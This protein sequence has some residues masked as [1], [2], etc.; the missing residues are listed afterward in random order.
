MKFQSCAVIFFISFVIG[1]LKAQ[2][3]MSSTDWEF[4]QIEKSMREKE[5]RV[6]ASVEENLA[7]VNTLIAELKPIATLSYTVQVLE[8][9]RDLLIK[10]STIT[11]FGNET[12]VLACENIPLRISQIRF[13]IDKCIRIKI[14]VDTNAVLIYV[15]AAKVN[16]AYAYNYFALTD[17]QRRSLMSI[18]TSLIVLFDEHNSYSV[19]QALAIYKYTRL[20]I[21]LLFCKKTFCNCPTQL[22]AASSSK[23][24]TVDAN[25]IEIQTSVD[26]REANIRKQSTVVLSK[27]DAVNPGLKK[28]ALYIFVTQTLDSIATLVK[29]YLILTTTDMINATT[30]CDEA[31]MKYAFIEYKLE[32][33]LQM[34]VEAAKNTTYVLTYLKNLYAF[35]AAVNLYLS[36]TEKK[37][38]KDVTDSM[39]QLVEEFRQYILTLAVAEVKLIIQLFDAKMARYGSCNC[40]ENSGSGMKTQIK[41]NLFFFLALTTF[42]SKLKCFFSDPNN[43]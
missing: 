24:A 34:S 35:S 41:L 5:N 39:T 37:G 6:R 20:Y 25:L 29:G 33:Y 43:M 14:Q 13:D 3:S 9:V 18:F 22:N 21:E 26:V 12:T 38:I 42:S 28:N 15:E 1:S 2:T 10:I 40:T 8:G 23:L 7:K 30:N 11:N 4:Q 31:A 19:V 17:A 36:E 27:V 32:L 16:G